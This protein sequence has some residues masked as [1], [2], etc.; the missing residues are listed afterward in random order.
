[1]T[2]LA[3]TN[4]P[5]GNKV[6]TESV[7]LSLN[8]LLLASPLGT[9]RLWSNGRQLVQ[10]EFGDRKTLPEGARQQGDAVLQRGG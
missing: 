3:S 8:Y 4:N 5:A 2:T 9:L 10:I 7:P 1:M 6:S